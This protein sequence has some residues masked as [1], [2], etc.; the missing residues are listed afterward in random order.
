MDTKLT[1]PCK[2]CPFRKKSLP[3][4]LG[5]WNA[6]ELIASI[7]YQPFPCHCTIKADSPTYDVPGLQSCAGAAIYLNNKLQL[8]RDP[9]TMKHQDLLRGISAELK[10]T[11][12]SSQKEFMDY[13]GERNRVFMESF[14]KKPRYANS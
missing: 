11:V 10:A 2:Q 12:F 5:P 6:D 7:G 1:E 3:G 8:A 14:E 4:Y 13:H 9:D